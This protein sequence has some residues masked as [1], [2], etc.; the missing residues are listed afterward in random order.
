M[1]ISLFKI[2]VAFLTF[3]SGIGAFLGWSVLVRKQPPAET[4]NEIIS[5]VIPVF[6]A[7]ELIDSPTEFDGKLISVAGTAYVY[8]K[9]IVLYSRNCSS[10]NYGMC[11]LTP[12][13]KLDDFQGTNNNLNVLLEDGKEVDVIDITGNKQNHLCL[14][15]C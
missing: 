6:S 14:S 13:L 5:E 2:T 15:K 8:D 12:E 11:C 9:T 10:S 4:P 7:C 1:K 3:L